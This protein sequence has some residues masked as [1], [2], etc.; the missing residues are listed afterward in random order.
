MTHILTVTLNPAVDITTTAESILPGPK[1]R[2]DTPVVEPGGG[3]VNV[4]RM[5]RI[6]GGRS[7]ALVATGGAT[8]DLVRALLA[9][10]DLDC[11]FVDACGDT[12]VNFAVH[13]RA[14]RDQYRFVL[15]GPLQDEGFATRVLDR[16]DE[17]VR[18]QGDVCVVGSG[19]LPPG[20]P[21]DFYARLGERVDRLG[22]RFVLDTSGPALVAGL[23]PHVSLVKPNDIEARALADS[24]GLAPD[25]YTGLG[26]H[27]VAAGKTRAA[28]LTLGEEGAMLVTERG[29][30]RCRPPH[31]PVVSKVGA[32][33]SFV[34]AMVHGMTTGMTI[35]QAF[36]LGVSAATAA[37]MTPS[38]RL[39]R[40]KDV[41]RIYAGLQ[42]T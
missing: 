1:L 18:A 28:V 19:S 6:L 23:G 14:T 34:G 32:G 16:V 40:R 25:D 5:I 31:V 17:V 9:R 10:E 21:D 33:D 42:E 13:E 35:E 12:R 11:A 4:S 22:A 26:Q 36:E 38:T 3:G 39:A 29:V 27:L 8:G 2:C 41:E 30:S 24:L 15:P 7:T 20:L 37:V